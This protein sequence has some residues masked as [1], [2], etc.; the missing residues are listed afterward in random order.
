MTWNGENP[1]SVGHNDVSALTENTKARFFKR[2]DSFEMID[3]SQ[4][5]HGSGNCDFNHA[6]AGL[7]RQLLGGFNILPNGDS[8]VGKGLLF[9]CPLRPAPG[10]PGARYAE[11]LFGLAEND[12]IY[13]HVEYVTPAPLGSA[14]REKG[15]LFQM[16]C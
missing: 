12:A 16:H 11:S 15:T 14:E 9:G 7:T 6:G 4:F 1:R 5:R 3:A 8:D 10:Q 2:S 13:R